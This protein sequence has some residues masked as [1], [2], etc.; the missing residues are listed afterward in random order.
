MKKEWNNTFLCCH[1]VIEGTTEKILQL[2][3]L[4]SQLKKETL[5]FMKKNVFVEYCRKVKTIEQR[6]RHQCRKNSLKLPQ[7]SN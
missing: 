5:V 1:R 7:M 4:L 2:I 3:M 6:N